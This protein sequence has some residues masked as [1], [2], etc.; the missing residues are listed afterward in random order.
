MLIPSVQPL[1]GSQVWV[2]DFAAEHSVEA[3]QNTTADPAADGHLVDPL[4]YIE[5]Q[6]AWTLDG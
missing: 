5:L 6:T 3:W 2:G 4:W 1:A